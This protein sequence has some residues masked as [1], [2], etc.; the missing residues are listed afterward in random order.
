MR[1]IRTYLLLSL[2]AIISLVIFVSLLHGYNSSMQK[3]QQIFDNRLMSMARIIAAANQKTSNKDVVP[4]SSSASLFFQIWDETGQ[5]IVRSSTAPEKM[6]IDTAADLFQE[7]NFA[8]FRWRIYH[9]SDVD[10]HRIIVVG[11]RIDVRSSLA[12]N[13]VL[14]SIIPVV[15]ALP[16]AAIIIWLAVGLGLKPLKDLS[17]QLSHKQ[18]RDLSP[19]GLPHLPE[20]LKQLVVTINALLRR[21]QENFDREKRFTA[22]VAH[23]LRT[24]ISLLKVQFHNLETTYHASPERLRPLGQAIERMSGVVEQIL[25]LYRHSHE[26]HIHHQQQVDLQAITQER[27]IEYYDHLAAKHQTISLIAEEGMW[28]EGNQFALE[29]LIQNLI[30]NAN[31]YTPES[32]QIH[33]TIQRTATTIEFVIEDSGPGIAE[34]ERQRVFDRF[35]RVQGDQHPSGTIGCGLGLSIVKHIAAMHHATIQLGDASLGGLKV[36]LSFSNV[37]K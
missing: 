34:S 27:I 2:I 16:V 35:Y 20:E 30:T 24:P 22:D 33:I 26:Q 6:I 19:V 8:N 32:G 12:E 14:A 25:S 28:V 37:K 18:A 23:E 31:K 4:L 17:R 10:L 11:E 7:A 36:T 13:I 29:T 1:S 15:I 3:T 21:L 9:F 5:L